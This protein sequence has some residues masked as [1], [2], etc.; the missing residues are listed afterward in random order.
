MVINIILIVAIIG[1][2]GLI[3]YNNIKKRQSEEPEKQIEVDDKTYTIEKMTEYVKKRLDEITKINLY[4]I[5][6]SEEELKRRK[7]K[8]C[9]KRMYIW[10]C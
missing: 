9:F 7:N 4:D 3:I 1:I 5:G 6:L 10:R 8:K 2:T